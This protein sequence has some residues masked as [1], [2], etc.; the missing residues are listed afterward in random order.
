MPYNPNIHNCR[1]I[2]LKGYDY[3]MVGLYFELIECF[4][5]TFTMSS[6]D[7]RG[8]V[9]TLYKRLNIEII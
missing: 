4:N 1:S 3:S 6:E 7:T 9:Y 8:Y 5:Y 2:R